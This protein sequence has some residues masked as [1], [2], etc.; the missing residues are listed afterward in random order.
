MPV[1]DNLKK[2]NEQTKRYPHPLSGESAKIKTLYATGVGMMAL[3][4]DHVIDENEKAYLENLMLSLYISESTLPVVIASATEGAETTILALVQSLRTLAHKYAFALDLLAIMRVG[5]SVGAE[6]KEKLKHFV[7]LV[8]ITTADVAFIATFSSA[9][10]T[11]SAP[12]VDKALMEGQ[13]NGV[14]PEPAL[15]KY[16]CPEINPV[17]LRMAAEM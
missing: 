8:R 5:E 10:A 13:K 7:D 17:Q 11:K 4:S 12:L 14:Y 3:S 16:F 1:L 6:S 9:C 2:L 15:L